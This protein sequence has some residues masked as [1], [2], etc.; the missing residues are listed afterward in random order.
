MVNGGVGR[1]LLAADLRVAFHALLSSSFWC[2]FASFVVTLFAFGPEAPAG[3]RGLRDAASRRLVGRRGGV[4]AGDGRLGRRQAGDG[5]AGAGTGDVGEADV[6]AEADGGRVAAVLA[7]DTHLHVGSR[8]AAPA[9]GEFH[10]APHALHV[11][12]LE[13]VVLEHL[14]LVVHGQELVFRVLP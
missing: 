14:L 3:G 7:A 2:Y 5:D 1:L 6:V 4:A 9:H 13:G 8:T 12:H 11:Q 10:Q